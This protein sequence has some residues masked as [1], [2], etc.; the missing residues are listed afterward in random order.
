MHSKY[1]CIGVAIIAVA[2]EHMGVDSGIDSLWMVCPLYWG[3]RF[4]YFALRNRLAFLDFKYECIRFTLSIIITSAVFYVI[5]KL[6]ENEQSLFIPW[7]EIRNAVWYALLAYIAKLIWDMFQAEFSRQ[8]EKSA[9]RVREITIRRYLE[10]SEKYS[11]VVDYCL[12]EENPLIEFQSALESTV[13]AIMI[14]EDYNR[15]IFIRRIETFLMQNHLNQSQAMTLGVMQIRTDKVISDEERI[16]T[17]IKKI[18]DDVEA[19]SIPRKCYLPSMEVWK[20]I[21]VKK[22]FQK[23]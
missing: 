23:Y 7:D 22:F 1:C 16:R 13:Y 4:T 20:P 2:Y 17:A 18:V 12:S 3:V 8:N 19:P 14:Y 6:R 15:P 21:L 9:E 5:C 10:F 11:D